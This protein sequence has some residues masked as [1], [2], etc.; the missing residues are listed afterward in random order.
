[1]GVRGAY[2]KEGN[3]RLSECS[4][5]WQPTIGPLGIIIESFPPEVQKQ[6]CER[7]QDLARVYEDRGDIPSSYYA[8]ALSGEEFP[9]PQS[10]GSHL[11]VV[12]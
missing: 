8:R 12:K 1:M 7:L 9:V 10:K 6:I 5:Y 2:Q 4:S 3:R 11:K